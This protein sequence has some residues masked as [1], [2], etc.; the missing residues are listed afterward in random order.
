MKNII[1]YVTLSTLTLIGCNKSTEQSEYSTS[2]VSISPPVKDLQ[3]DNTNKFDNS[4]KIIKS[5]TINIETDSIKALYQ[6]IS[7]DIL[8]FNGY[9]EY[10][11]QTGTLNN[12]TQTIN[13]KIPEKRFDEF[14]NK[15]SFTQGQITLKEIKR[16]DITKEYKETALKI[17]SY[18]ALEMRYIEL[19]AKA[20][21]VSEMIEI[22]AKLNEIK[23][24]IQNESNHFNYL[25]K[26]LKYSTIEI[27][28]I[29]NSISNSP[30]FST[31]IFNALKGG[32]SILK[33]IILGLITLWPIWL[34]VALGIVVF[35]KYIKK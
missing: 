20:S 6:K 8:K 23:S 35:K 21:K 30:K 16:T 7:N 3:N 5:A 22:E 28:L 4:Q 27:T 2:E 19:L 12:L 34:C 25:N 31:E 17:D 9:I 33:S 32:F 1:L 15:L 10:E 29:S 24:S 13:C 14:V 26:Q 18:K 11:N